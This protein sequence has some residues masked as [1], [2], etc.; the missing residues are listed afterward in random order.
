MKTNISIDG[1]TA[2]TN[3]LANVYEDLRSGKIKRNDAKVL[4]GVASAI[5]RASVAKAIYYRNMD[6]N[7]PVPFLEN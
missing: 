7:K 3:D 2:L 5:I 4:H 6:I 1:V